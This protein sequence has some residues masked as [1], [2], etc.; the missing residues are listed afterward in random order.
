MRAD[1]ISI[2][3]HKLRDFIKENGKDINV[4]EMIRILHDVRNEVEE[5]AMKAT[6]ASMCI[7]IIDGPAGLRK[8]SELW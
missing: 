7:G 5:C 1:R 6:V 8:E 2:F 3:K 4:Y